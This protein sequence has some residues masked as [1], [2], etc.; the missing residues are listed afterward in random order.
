M[1][2]SNIVIHP[3][4]MDAIESIAFAFLWEWF[5]ISS[6]THLNLTDVVWPITIIVR[7]Q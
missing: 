6:D 3:W 2:L 1:S 7:L 4:R 5:G